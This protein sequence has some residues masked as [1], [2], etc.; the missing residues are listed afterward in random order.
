MRNAV[1]AENSSCEQLVMAGEQGRRSV[2]HP[3]ALSFE[4]GDAP[5]AL[6][7]A[8]EV[9]RHVEA[10]ERDVAGAQ[11]EQRLA[12]GEQVRAH[13]LPAARGERV[14]RLRQSMRDD[15]ELHGQTVRDGPVLMGEQAANG[16]K[17]ACERRYDELVNA[18]LRSCGAA[19]PPELRSRGCDGH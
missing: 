7:D 5:D 9:G 13:A 12:R 14:V 16:S 17:Q 8:V 3:D 19:S 2:Q 18:Q 10:I 15:G 4:L 6:L 11:S 1:R